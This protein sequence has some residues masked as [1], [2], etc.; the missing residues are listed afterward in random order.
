MS[1]LPPQLQPDIA[2]QDAVHGRIWLTRLER[3]VVNTAEFQRLR[4]IGQLGLGR[5]VFPS[6]DHSRFVHSLGA[7]HVMGWMLR[8]KPLQDYFAERVGMIQCLRLAAL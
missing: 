6:A 5:Y 3:H 4:S 7:T 8:Q 2:V 1:D